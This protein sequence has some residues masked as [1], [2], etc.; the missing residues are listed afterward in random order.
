MKPNAPLR[1][2]TLDGVGKMI[3][4]VTRVKFTGI[5]VHEGDSVIVEANGDGQIILTLEN[6]DSY[7]QGI[8]EISEAIQLAKTILKLSGCQIGA[9]VY[10][11]D[12]ED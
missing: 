9:L 3:E 1:L 4:N 5:K 2:A 10:P 12:K 7:I 6:P 8:Y 11:K